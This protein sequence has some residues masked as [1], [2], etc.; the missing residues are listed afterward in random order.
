VVEVALT[1]GRAVGGVYNKVMKFRAL[2]ES[3]PRKDLIAGSKIDREI[4]T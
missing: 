3:D 4:W 1:I 2:D